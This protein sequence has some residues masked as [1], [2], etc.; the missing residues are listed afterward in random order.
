[1]PKV[2]II[3]PVYNTEQYLTRCLDTVVSQSFNDIEIICVNDGSTDFSPK[4]LDSYAKFDNRI[5]VI[6]RVNGGLSSARNVG[7]SSAKGDYIL[8]VD[9]DDWIS[10]NTVDV[11][12]KN[13][14][15]N[16]SDIV[17]FAYV[18]ANSDLAPKT[19]MGV[20]ECQAFGN[21][22]AKSIPD[23][24]LKLFPVAAW[25][26]FY[27][28]E[29]IKNNNIIFH[30]NIIFEDVPFWAEVF[31]QAQTISYENEPFYFY[32]ENR[33]GQITKQV[34]ETVFDIIKCYEVTE[35]AYQKRNL[36]EKY[37]HPLQ[38]LMM[39]DFMYKY[40]IIMPKLKQKL[41]NAYKD[42][43]KDIDY[44]YFHS[45]KLLPF[46]EVACRRFQKLNN[47]TFEEFEEYLRGEANANT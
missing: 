16:N 19:F 10:T 11:L 20:P 29:F 5:R 22:N 40:Y 35:N 44:E 38:M 14:I 28:T 36:W 46:E 6:N 39:L 25:C 3:I 26:K 4:I 21:F 15:K 45:Q 8:F 43:K 17:L 9:S 24:A 30:E 37:K 18:K 32:R 12:Y 7:I 13:A 33:E 1:M 23:E 34:G 27:K 41:F 42:L 31:T 2:S 47:S